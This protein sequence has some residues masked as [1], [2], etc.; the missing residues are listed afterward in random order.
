MVSGEESGQVLWLVQHGQTTW[1]SMGWVQGHEDRARFTRLG[2]R[3]VRRAADR[4]GEQPVTAVYSSDLLQ[5]RRTAMAIARRLRC[6]VRTDRRLRERKFGIAEG[7][8][9][10]DVPAAA[11]GIVGGCVVDEMAHPPG[12]ET[13]HELYARCLSFLLDVAEQPHEGDV[14]V[15]AHDG[16]IRMLRG[17]VGDS[18]IFGLSWEPTP[19]CGEQPIGV[20]LPVRFDTAS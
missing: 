4:F 14:V 19:K 12:G 10:A 16:S 6:D 2:R 1:N 17:I 20:R 13:L 11:T 8:P 3:E 7:V 9:W 5:A 18:D 15:V